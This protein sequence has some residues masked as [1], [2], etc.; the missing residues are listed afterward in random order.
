MTKLIGWGSWGPR[1]GNK[2]KYGGKEKC[3]ICIYE[4]KILLCF[5][6]ENVLK[7]IIIT[8]SSR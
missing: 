8:L 5:G 7:E 6:K 3:L 1:T 2:N 4:L